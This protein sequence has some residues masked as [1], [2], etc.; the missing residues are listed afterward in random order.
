M[1]KEDIKQLIKEELD[2][3]QQAKDAAKK[4]ST[5]TVKGFKPWDQMNQV[6]YDS[7]LAGVEWARKNPSNI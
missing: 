5:K 6:Q 7:F 3:L 2:D 4:H 1:K